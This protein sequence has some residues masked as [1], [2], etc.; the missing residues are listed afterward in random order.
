VKLGTPDIVAGEAFVAVRV[1][2][3]MTSRS[4]DRSMPMDVVDIYQLRE[5]KIARVDVFY[6]DTA[7]VVGLGQQEASQDENGSAR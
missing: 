4:T 1:N 7:A 2:G 6:K 3:T 5:G